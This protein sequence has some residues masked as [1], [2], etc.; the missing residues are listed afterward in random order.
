[1][2]RKY[3]RG[4]LTSGG[5]TLAIAGGQGSRQATGNSP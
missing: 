5:S 3:T 4:V 1:M 2:T